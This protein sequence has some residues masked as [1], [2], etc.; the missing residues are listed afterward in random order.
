MQR[1]SSSNEASARI[2][3]SLIA[4]IDITLQNSATISIVMV[5]KVLYYYFLHCMDKKSKL[6]VHHVQ[7]NAIIENIFQ[8]KQHV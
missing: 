4:I 1:E 7:N 5:Q 3:S 2:R 6:E 8:Q